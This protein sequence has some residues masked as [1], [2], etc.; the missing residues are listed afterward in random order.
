MY[1]SG[2]NLERDEEG[3]DPPITTIPADQLRWAYLSVNTTEIETEET[4]EGD[5]QTPPS[6]PPKISW[7]KNI[8]EHSLD[9][10]D[11]RPPCMSGYIHTYMFAC[12]HTCLPANIMMSVYLDFK[13]SVL[14]E[15]LYFRHFHISRNMEIWKSSVP[16]L[17]QSLLDSVP[18]SV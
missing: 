10:G 17:D 13:I 7:N 15:F 2:H 6:P 14:P 4:D 9:R 18:Q 8:C 11:S 5:P 12:I 3:E 16:F 1:F